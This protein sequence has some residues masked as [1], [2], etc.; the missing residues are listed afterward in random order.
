MSLE[1]F[2]ESTNILKYVSRFRERLHMACSRS[3]EALA[4]SQSTMKRHYDRRAVTRS[5]SVRDQSLVLLPIP[6]SALSAQFSGPYSIE[7]KLSDIDYVISTPDCR[8]KTRVCHINMLKLY[9]AGVPDS[10]EGKISAI[11]SV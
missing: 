6:G 7:Q 10:S 9:H 8:R 3:R 1:K 5:F 11:T 2:T 4:A